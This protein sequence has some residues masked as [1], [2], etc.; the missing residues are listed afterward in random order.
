MSDCSRLAGLFT[1]HVAA[2]F[3]ASAGGCVSDVYGWDCQVSTSRVKLGFNSW[4]SVAA[5]IASVKG[6]TM[7]AGD[8][9]IVTK[10]QNSLVLSTWLKV[11]VIQ[12]SGRLLFH[13]DL[14]DFISCPDSL[15]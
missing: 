7:A 10:E 1:P 9:G 4:K 2:C 5:A 15:A 6:C 8:C 14:A 3:T 11:V 12:A 13:Q